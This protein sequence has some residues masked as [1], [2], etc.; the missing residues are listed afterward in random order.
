[1]YLN[2]DIWHLH[3][4]WLYLGKCFEPEYT[5]VFLSLPGQKVIWRATWV[6]QCLDT[7]HLLGYYMVQMK[8]DRLKSSVCVRW[9]AE[10][11]ST[12]LHLLEI[13]K[14]LDNAWTASWAAESLW[15]F[16]IRFLIC[17]SAQITKHKPILYGSLGLDGR[18]MQF[19]IV[20]IEWCEGNHQN[21]GFYF[22]FV[23]CF[24]CS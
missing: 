11:E 7:D 5:N 10:I 21:C 12:C 22:R 13:L 19:E 15:M 3:V 17:C 16:K 20:H 8:K 2:K 23:L 14:S 1:M 9:E 18:I 6:G 24:Y 4:L